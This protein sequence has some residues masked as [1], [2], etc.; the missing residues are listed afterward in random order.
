MSAAAS[1]HKEQTEGHAGVSTRNV[2]LGVAVSL[3][4]YKRHCA[5]HV[6]TSISKARFKDM[7]SSGGTYDDL[8][9]V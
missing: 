6:P 5:G 8:Q 3:D 7:I 2:V 4:G 9:H 1:R